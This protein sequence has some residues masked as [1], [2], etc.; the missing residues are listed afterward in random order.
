MPVPRA[1]NP[2]IWLLLTAFMGALF[3]L[4]LYQVWKLEG[5]WFYVVVVAIALVCISLIFIRYF[6][7][8]LLAAL[9]FCIPLGSFTKWLFLSR[10]PDQ[11]A[12]AMPYSGGLSVGITELV[13]AGLYGAWFLRVFATRSEPLPRFTGMD[14]C[15]L[16]VILAYLLSIPGTKDASLGVFATVYLI[17]HVAIYVYLSRHLQWRHLLWFLMSVGFTICL[18]GSIGVLQNR[19]GMFA[20]LA[21]DKAKGGEDLDYQYEVPGMEDMTRAT[22]TLYDS[23]ALGTYVSMLALYMFVTVYAPFIAG[24]LRALAAALFMLAMATLIISFSRSAWLS[25]VV[26][27]TLVTS[28]FL[29]V[30]KQTRI[31]PSIFILAFLLA[32]AVP[33]AVETIYDRFANAPD[34]IISVRFEQYE[35]AFEIWKHHPFLG[36][37]VG[38]Y[39]YTLDRHNFNFA[40]ELPVHNMPLWI[41]AES[42]LVGL[43]AFAVLFLGTLG[44]LWRF[45]L[46]AP[47]PLRYIGAAAFGSVVIYLV[48]AMSNP[49]FRDPVLFKMFWFHAALATALPRIQQELDA[50]KA[51]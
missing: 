5:R 37:G 46:Y 14:L 45:V 26:G 38:N 22:G 32:P 6:T 42:G 23:H 27:L 9:L 28:I 39:M 1:E 20:G 18:E 16:L 48:D 10:Y 49:L 33:W 51:R 2:L 50:D 12:N 3:A 30:W 13:L 24:R 19:F 21:L 43:S 35:V 36:S 41:A 7:D 8:F 25:C 11:V 4:G 31:I 44:R 40:E 17:M 34:Q 29:F 47:D 15:A